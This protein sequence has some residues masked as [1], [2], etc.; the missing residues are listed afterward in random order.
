MDVCQNQ[1]VNYMGQLNR[2]GT[3]IK[4]NMNKL[5]LYIA[6]LKENVTL[7]IVDV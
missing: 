4:A 3:V 5:M 2:M 6:G 7:L 1:G